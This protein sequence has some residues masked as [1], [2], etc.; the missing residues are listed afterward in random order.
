[1]HIFLSHFASAFA[2]GGKGDVGNKPLLVA[3]ASER[4]VHS[5]GVDID[6]TRDCSDEI[7]LESVEFSWRKPGAIV[8]KHKLKTFACGLGG[9]AFPA[10][11]P[12]T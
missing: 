12:I 6:V 10:E 4:H 2:R 1:L 9:S 7:V 11:E 5:A 8:D 3:V